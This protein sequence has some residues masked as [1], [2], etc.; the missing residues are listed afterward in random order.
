M[1]DLTDTGDI[2]EKMLALWKKVDQ[3]KISHMEA[4]VHIGIARTILDTLKV[5]IAAAHLEV[6]G[7]P[8]VP[9][10]GKKSLKV[11]QGKKAA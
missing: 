4:R 3:G 1:T 5:E 11:I 9:L 2:R 10:A 6:A 8:K 7:I